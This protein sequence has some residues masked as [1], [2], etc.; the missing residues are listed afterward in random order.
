MTDQ[1]LSTPQEIELK[2]DFPA[3]AHALVAQHVTLLENVAPVV[4]THLVTIYYD[5]PDLALSRSGLSLR[6]RRSGRHHVQTLKSGG[7]N[8]LATHRNEWEWPVRTTRPD[9]TLLDVTPAAI[10]KPMLDGKLV[11]VFRSDIQRAIHMMRCEDAV[12]EIA[13][14]EGSVRA[15]K[16]EEQVH[17]VE[18]ELKNGPVLPLY[19][20]AIRLQADLP[21]H[22]S[23]QT[24][25]GRG[26]RLLTR[27]SAQVTPARAPV[28]SAK[29]TAADG[30][31]RIMRED[32][33]SLVNNLPAVKADDME[34]IHQMRVA[35]RRLRT[36]LQL[37]SVCL[38]DTKATQFEDGLQRIGRILG[39]ARDWDVFSTE[40]LRTAS[41]ALPMQDGWQALNTAATGLRT[42]VHNALQQELAGPD[43]TACVL[44]L[45]A[46][47][48]DAPFRVSH[49]KMDHKLIALAPDLLDRV[50]RKVVRRGRHISHLSATELH[51]LRKTL[52]KLR[53]SVDSMASLYPTRKVKSYLKHCRRLQSCLGDIN[54]AAVALTLT[55]RL[56]CIQPDLSTEACDTV[57]RWSKKRR[58]QAMRR[59]PQAW[60]AFHKATPFWRS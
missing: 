53:Y 22:I 35:I 34:G 49:K 51:S 5:T 27:H 10:L 41:P 33:D 23:A 58:Q 4:H 56:R 44:A 32:M 12:I 13:I 8:A 1:H 29:I 36:T 47:M 15:G 40:T 60:S 28:L 37:F 30:F 11:P 21:L 9:I 57:I 42:Q 59:L 24:K 46:W 26:Y 17:E 25:A 48:E 38:D 14:D 7:D 55:D 39:A 54:D 18:L 20:L 2:L 43:I 19:H 16:T 3:E 52:K 45:T 50:T 6:V 31:R